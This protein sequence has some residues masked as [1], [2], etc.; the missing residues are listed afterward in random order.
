MSAGVLQQANTACAQYF[1]HADSQN[2]YHICVSSIIDEIFLFIN[3][4]GLVPRM[5]QLEVEQ[6]GV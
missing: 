6:A 3:A 2:Q 1:V 5:R 4:C